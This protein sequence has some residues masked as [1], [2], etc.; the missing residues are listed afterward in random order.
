M[1][2][3]RPATPEE[4]EKIKNESD[5]GANTYVLALDTQHGTAVAVVR[6]AVEADPVHFPPDFPTKLKLLFMRDIETHLAAKGATEYYFNIHA[7]EEPYITAM[8]KTFEAQQV[9]QVP[10]FRF[11]KN[12]I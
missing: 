10:E 11:R 9:S 7:D 6:M 4:V 12:L 3:L 1:N 5:L 8:T 2:R